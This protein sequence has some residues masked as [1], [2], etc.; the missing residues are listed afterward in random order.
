LA[1]KQSKPGVKSFKLKAPAIKSPD[2]VASSHAQQPPTASS[3]KAL[4]AE[5]WEQLGVPPD[6]QQ[7]QEHSVSQAG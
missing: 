3:S 2:V 1:Q 5:A 4:A 6:L 7:L